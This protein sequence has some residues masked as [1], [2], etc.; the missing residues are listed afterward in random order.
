[1]FASRSREGLGELIRIDEELENVLGDQLVLILDF[2][3]LWYL[4]A[5]KTPKKQLSI[6]RQ[7][8]HSNVLLVEKSRPDLFSTTKKNN[9]TDLT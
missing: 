5:H 7:L 3:H 2:M 9:G 1:L 6:P 8:G 4:M